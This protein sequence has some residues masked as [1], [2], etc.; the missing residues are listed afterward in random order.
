M[1]GIV[2]IGGHQYKVKPG[3]VIDVQ[4]LQDEEGK[5][6]ELDEV[7]FVGGEKP[8]VGAPTVQ[9]A[10][11]KAQVIRQAR[12]RKMIIFKRK[13]GL[14]QKKNGHRQHYTGL[15]ITELEDGQGGVAKIEADNK[16]AKKYLK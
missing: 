7:L 10:K 9:G 16:Y 6:I 11:I 5:S 15:L 2:K 12:S 3:D 8:Q 4:K 14:Y 1:Y 13:P